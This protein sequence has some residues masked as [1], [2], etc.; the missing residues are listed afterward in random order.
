M[1]ETKRLYLDDAK[2]SDIDTIME[3]ENH[4][5]NRNFVWKGTYKEHKEEIKNS[6]FFLFVVKQKEDS[7][8]VGFCLIHLDNKSRRFEL[9]RFVISKKRMGYGSEVI[10]GL[11]KFA[12]ENLKMNKFWLD[13]YPDNSAGIKLYEK[14]GMHRDGVLR[15][16]YKS[17]RGYLDQVVY[18]MLKDEYFQKY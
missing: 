9:R 6:D 2:E 18:S 14:V 13:V 10:T 15:Q 16:N 3:L 1:I 8:T 4:K 17:E 5:D 12:F 11:F 7:E